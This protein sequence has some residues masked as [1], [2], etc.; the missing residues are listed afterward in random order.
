MDIARRDSHFDCLKG[1]LIFVVVFGHIMDRSGFVKTTKTYSSYFLAL[2]HVFHMPAFV[3]ISGYFSKNAGEGSNYFTK[4]LTTL[5]FPFI[6][7]HLLSRALFYWNVSMLLQPSFTTWYLLSL[8][9][10]KIF[11]VP[12]SKIR[13][14]VLFAA[15]VV[16]A[17]YTGLTRADSFMSIS[18]TICFFP[19]FIAGYYTRPA[20]VEK[21][22][23]HKITALLAFV[24]ALAVVIYMMDHHL[25]TTTAFQ[26]VRPYDKFKV[27]TKVSV[28]IRL[29]SYIL[30]F[31]STYSLVAL[32]PGKGGIFETWGRNSMTIYLAHGLLISGYSQCLKAMGITLHIAQGAWVAL[33]LLAT[34]L[35]CLAFGNKYVTKAYDAFMNGV[36]RLVLKSG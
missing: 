3:F 15:S 13:G 7:F 30:G 17:L 22:R 16:L 14:V 36:S 33:M 35:I 27:A 6:I 5:L 1:I 31:V 21:L 2:I 10:W 4:Q 11:I 9:F 28:G 8:F 25:P 19:Y 20:L 24:A 18:R 23:R 29:A 12:F 32:A 34:V 26:M